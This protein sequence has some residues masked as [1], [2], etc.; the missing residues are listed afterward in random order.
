VN[1]NFSGKLIEVFDCSNSELNRTK[2]FIASGTQHPEKIEDNFFF[3][4]SYLLVFSPI[5]KVEV[6]EKKL[7]KSKLC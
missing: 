7:F 1:L 4:K 2:S 3:D 5:E 6:A